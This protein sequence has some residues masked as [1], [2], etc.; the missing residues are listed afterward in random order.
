MARET[1]NYLH[2]AGRESRQQGARR[3]ADKNESA[4]S[5]SPAPPRRFAHAYP[6]SHRASLLRGDSNTERRKYV[7]VIVNMA[8]ERASYIL[9]VEVGPKRRGQGGKRTRARAAAL[10]LAS[11]CCGLG[12]SVTF[13]PNPVSSLAKH[14]R[15]GAVR[16]GA[17]RCGTVR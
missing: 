10:D 3:Q 9:R 17:V 6:A 2:Q 15:C 4:W 11:R 12:L 1:A 16:C 8:R 13:N 14:A 7:N 5:T